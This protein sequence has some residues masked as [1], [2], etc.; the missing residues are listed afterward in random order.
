[1]DNVVTVPFVIKLLK[2][3]NR[4]AISSTP[5]VLA[6]ERRSFLLPHTCEFPCTCSFCCPVKREYFDG[7]WKVFV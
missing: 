1:M 5:C 6:V 2:G 4:I 3:V 7:G